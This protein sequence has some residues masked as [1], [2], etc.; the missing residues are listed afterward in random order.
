MLCLVF[1]VSVMSG[2]CLVKKDENINRA[3]EKRMNKVAENYVKLILKVGIFDPDYVDAYYGPQ[4]WKPNNVEKIKADT[5]SIQKL[6][7][8][9]GSLLDSLEVL[10]KEKASELEVLRYKY[11]YKQLLAVRARIFMLAGGK[12]SFDDEV[13]N[14]YDASAPTHSPEFFS[15]IIEELD[16][17]VPGQGDLNDRLTKYKSSFI[18]PVD[19]LDKVF[20]AAIKECRQ[21]TLEHI[22]LPQNENFKVEYVPDAP[23]GA[24]NWYKGN[25]FSVIQVNTKLPV[26][27]DRAVDLAAHEGYPGHHVYNALLEQKMVK[28]HGWKE[29]T[30]YPLFSPQS[31]IAEGSANYGINVAFPGQQRIKFEKEVLFPLAGLDPATAD[32]YYKISELQ[33]KLT[34]A[35]N[36]A[37]RF[38]IDGKFSREQAKQWLMKYSIMNEERAEQRMRFIDKYR[39]YVVNYNLGQ[40]IVKDYITRQN[41]SEGYPETTWNLFE[42]LLST[43]QVP[44]NLITR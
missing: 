27:I 22:K 4:E 30:V 14:L 7:D 39:S 41:G 37:A 9:S 44:S 3:L 5:T 19:K 18:V 12:F 38:Y 35:G 1:T 43:P 20:S 16:R 8:E 24:Y 33:G 26:Y 23:W 25:S 34:Y 36:E 28:E 6:Y 13:K 10:S 40:D 17:I 2:G 29:F 15:A 32:L 42:R 31:L 21:R 11:L